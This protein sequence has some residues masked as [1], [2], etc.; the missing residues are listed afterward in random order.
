MWTPPISWESWEAKMNKQFLFCVET[1]RRANTDYQYIRETLL[2]FYRESRKNIIRPVYLESKSRY[3]NNAVM[4]EIRIKQ[5]AFPGETH[6]IYFIDTDL[7]D[8]SPEARQELEEIRGFCDTNKFDFVFF[9]RDVEEV[10]CGSRIPSTAKIRCIEQFKR[11]HT[12]QT[13]EADHLQCEQ[14]H[15]HCSNI[16][17]VLD[18]YWTRK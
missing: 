3:N 17:N 12:I 13:V 2:H 14:Y 1:N 9:C 16:L 4:K 15:I 10:F 8:V 5:K 18:K 6:V 11:N 7:S